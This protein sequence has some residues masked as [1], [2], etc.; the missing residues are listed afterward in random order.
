M[1]WR[2]DDI[3]QMMS[4][5]NLQINTRIAGDGFCFLN[6]VL[7]CL[8]YNHNMQLDPETLRN[9]VVEEIIQRKEF[10]GDFQTGEILSK[11]FEFFDKRNYR[12]DVLDVIIVATINAFSLDVDTYQECRG[13][14]Q[15][16]RQRGGAGTRKISLFYDKTALHYMSIRRI[17]CN[18][19]ENKS[20][21]TQYT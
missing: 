3:V 8:T 11:V 15:I 14:V 10:Y 13:F 17:E 19:E 2:K 6:S 16:L 1:R 18:T 20:T 7:D 12:L 4:S 9:M 21:K 5:K